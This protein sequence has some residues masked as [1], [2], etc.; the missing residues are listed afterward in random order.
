MLNDN[1]E[2]AYNKVNEMKNAKGIALHDLLTELHSFV[3]LVD[4]PTDIRIYLVTKMA[5][6]EQRLA[7]GTNERLQTASLVSC[8][9]KAKNMA[10]SK[11]WID[12]GVY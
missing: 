1:Y 4:F 11:A 6:I 10:A 3:H 2:Q 9:Q 8:F 12:Y 5:L 7:S